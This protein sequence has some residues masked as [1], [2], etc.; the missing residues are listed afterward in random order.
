[1]KLQQQHAPTP[2]RH[3]AAIILQ[4]AA[5][6][7][8]IASSHCL[9]PPQMSCSL[10]GKREAVAAACAASADRRRGTLSPMQ[11]QMV[12]LH[13]HMRALNLTTGLHLTGPLDIPALRRTLEWLAQRHEVLR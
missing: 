10:A 2:R 1:M 3:A 6:I 8:K 7:F 9:F 13:F 12:L 4:R 11:R 5:V